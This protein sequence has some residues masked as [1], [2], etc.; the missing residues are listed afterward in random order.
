LA[1]LG[2]EQA[3]GRAEPEDHAAFLCEIMAGLAMRRLP[4]PPGV[5]R[6]LFEVHLAPW[7]GQFFSDLERAEAAALYRSIGAFG[8]LFMTI[9][10]EAFALPG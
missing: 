5:D 8:R 4:I 2:I 9:E 10:A 6:T 3:P 1:R 7:M